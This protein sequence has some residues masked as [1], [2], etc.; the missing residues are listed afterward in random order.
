MMMAPAAGTRLADRR[1]RA[2]LLLGF[3][4]ALRRS[5][6]VALDINDIE[7]TKEGLRVTIRR[8]KT[9]QEGKG[10]TV[11]IVRG[12][13][14]CP[15]AAYKAWIKAANITAGPVFRPIAKGER[16]HRAPLCRTPHAT[17]QGMRCLRQLLG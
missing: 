14:S 15:V 12:A 13:V 11:A 6:L 9:D 10:A 1:D 7:E 3:A 8:G 17:T 4:G 5:E 2:L 16:P